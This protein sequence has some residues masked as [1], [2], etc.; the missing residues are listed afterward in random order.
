MHLPNLSFGWIVVNDVTDFGS[1][2]RRRMN[3]E[4]RVAVVAV[5]EEPVKLHN[6]RTAVDVVKGDH[7]AIGPGTL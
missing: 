1:S 2:L 7:P 4:L 3:E 5:E 6:A